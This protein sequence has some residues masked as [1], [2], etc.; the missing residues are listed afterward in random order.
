M[1]IGPD[2]AEGDFAGLLGWHADSA[3]NARDDEWRVLRPQPALRSRLPGPNRDADSELEGYFG[4]NIV[5][6]ATR[7]RPADVLIEPPT[8]NARDTWHCGGGAGNERT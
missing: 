3:Q 2:K 8:R 7:R 1:P 5:K 4:H 6:E